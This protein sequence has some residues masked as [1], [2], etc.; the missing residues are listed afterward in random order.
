[1]HVAACDGEEVPRLGESL[2]LAANLLLTAHLCHD[3]V[4]K[5]QKT[6][7]ALSGRSHAA[8]GQT[9][10]WLYGFQRRPF[11][12]LRIVLLE[13]PIVFLVFDAARTLKPA[14]TIVSSH[15]WP[16]C[17]FFIF[18]L[19]FAGYKRLAY[20]LTFSW[21]TTPRRC[22]IWL[23]VYFCIARWRQRIVRRSAEAKAVAVKLCQSWCSGTNLTLVACPVA[24]VFCVLLSPV[25]YFFQRIVTIIIEVHL[26]H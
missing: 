20:C 19:S 12:S 24:F 13:V 7:Q 22:C 26:L 6:K 14:L 9:I 3:V 5:K 4:G 18:L 8:S 23:N 25:S 21:P 10:F 15:L 11:C 16:P 17:C 1:M 2:Q